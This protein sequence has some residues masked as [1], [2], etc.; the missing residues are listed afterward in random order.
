[1]GGPSSWE[2]RS[3]H[4]LQSYQLSEV[5]RQ[6]I[7]SSSLPLLMAERENQWWCSFF[8]AFGLLSAVAFICEGWDHPGARRKLARS[9][10]ISP[11]LDLALVSLTRPPLALS[12]PE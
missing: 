10:F 7:A 9:Q 6:G 1:M 8:A 5:R 12:P 3:S 4:A 11:P 2:D